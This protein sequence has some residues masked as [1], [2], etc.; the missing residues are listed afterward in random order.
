MLVLYILLPVIGALPLIIT[1]FKMR[2]AQRIIKNGI[3][4]EAVVVQVNSLGTTIRNK[5]DILVL[6]YLV[7]ATNQIYQGK[8][9]ATREQYKVG[10]KLTITYSKFPPYEM[11]VKGTNVYI[12][13]LVFTILIFLFV[14]F[15]MIKIEELIPE[16]GYHLR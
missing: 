13:I 9:S 16:G 3:T 1:I 2:R 15:A 7:K 4:T 11:T 8:A 12:P 10:D 5:A 6:Q 14:L